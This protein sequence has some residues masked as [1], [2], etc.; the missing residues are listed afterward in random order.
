VSEN[1]SDSP[2]SIVVRIPNWVGDVVM[3]T[4]ALRALR[5]GF[6]GAHIAYLLRP[7]TEKILE[8]SPWHDETISVT[9]RGGGL[10]RVSGILRA[11]TFQ[12]GVL[13]TNS[14]A[15]ALAFW[16]GGVQR[17]VG[18]LREW[19]GS[20]L[21][22]KLRAPRGNGDF[23]PAPMVDYYLKLTAYLGC[24]TDSRRL[25]LFV[26]P[27]CMDACDRLFRKYRVDTGKP[28]VLVIAGA[29]FGSAKCWPP[30]RF[31]AVSD[32]LVEKL[33]AQVLVPVGPGEEEVAAGIEAA[34]TRPVLNLAPDRVG[35]DLLKAL[36]KRSSLVICNDSGPRHFAAAFDVPVVTIMGPTD[37]RWSDTGF[38]KETVIRKPVEC[39]PCMKRRCPRDHRCMTLITPEEVFEEASRKLAGAA[40]E[41][42]AENA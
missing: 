14:F 42:P 41:P 18:Y 26:S 23:L 1:R 36:V 8:P 2:E 29:A 39:A 12:L 30:E 27:E 10:W 37:P 16:L 4:P 13:L 32:M 22:D 24:E 34:S 9:A 33:G 11:R 21:T 15:S 35:L 5:Q 25:E 31:A 6:R 19:R 38:Q 40:D 20:L 17:R 3:A 7:Y 28:I